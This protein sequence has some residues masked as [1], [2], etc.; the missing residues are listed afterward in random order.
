MPA[1]DTDRHKQLVGQRLRLAIE[2]LGVTLS[3]VAETTGVE[4]S[5]LGHWTRGKHYP[6]PAWIEVFAKE[7]GIS[8]DWI[9][10]ERVSG[11]PKDLAV[12]LR[13]AAA[14]PAQHPPR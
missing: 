7:Y 13:S 1:M 2:G 3:Q 4:K 14:D 10:L 8:A 11:L 12:Y 6:D 9:Y 5:R